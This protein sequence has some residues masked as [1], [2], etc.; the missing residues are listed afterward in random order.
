MTMTLTIKQV[1]DSLVERLRHRA[2]SNRRSPQT[3]L[4]LMLERTLG[5]RKNELYST[6]CL[7]VWGQHAR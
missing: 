1:P 3:E 6:A 2:A 7:A 4:P 5:D